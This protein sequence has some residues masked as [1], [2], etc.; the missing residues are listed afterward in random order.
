M[1]LIP[2]L[3]LILFLSSPSIRAQMSPDDRRIPHQ[4]LGG[5]VVGAFGGLVGGGVGSLLTQTDD[6][7]WNRLAA[8]LGGSVIGFTLGNGAGVY[9]FGNTEVA[10]GSLAWTWAGSVSGLALGL[11]LGS[12]SPDL[13][14]PVLASSVTIGSM[15]GYNLTRTSTLTVLRP[16]STGLTFIRIDFH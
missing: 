3:F 4:I 14:L 11:G 10:K 2:L 6:T 5:T 13:L 15:V 7:G 9:H 1:R 16:T 12:K 8:V